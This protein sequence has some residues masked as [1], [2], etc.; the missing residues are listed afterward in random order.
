MCIVYL[1]TK[2]R[3]FPSICFYFVSFQLS[4]KSVMFSLFFYH[5]WKITWKL[6]FVTH[7]IFPATPHTFLFNIFC[8]L[9]ILLLS[10]PSSSTSHAKLVLFFPHVQFSSR[11]QWM[12]G[13]MVNQTSKNGNYSV[14][15]KSYL[16]EQPLGVNEQVSAWL[17]VKEMDKR[18]KWEKESEFWMRRGDNNLPWH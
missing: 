13:L 15:Y 1:R 16:N 10:L 2:H 12:G 9:F 4:A 17:W 5:D 6:S 3:D 7:K 14:E 11:K 8:S 18:R